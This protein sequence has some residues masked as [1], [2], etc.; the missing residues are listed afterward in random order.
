MSLELHR[1][2]VVERL[3]N[4]SVVEPVG[5]VECCPFDVLDVAP[6]QLAMDQLGLEEPVE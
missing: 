4:S 5:V 1:R 3:V 6:G 2:Y